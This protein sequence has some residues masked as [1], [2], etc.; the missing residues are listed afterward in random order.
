M[1]MQHIQSTI[2]V[3]ILRSLVFTLHFTL[4]MERIHN[5]MQSMISVL[6]LQGLVFNL[7]VYY[8]NKTDSQC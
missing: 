8:A 1:L 5:V 4:L 3:L 2:I 7:H 6:I